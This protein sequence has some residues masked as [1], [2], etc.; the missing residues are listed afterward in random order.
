MKPAASR[1]ARPGQRHPLKPSLQRRPKRDRHGSD[2]QKSCAMPCLQALPQ[3]EKVLNLR[4]QTYLE[5]SVTTHLTASLPGT[6]VRR[7]AAQR[8][9]SSRPRS[10]DRLKLL[11]HRR[12]PDIANRKSRRSNNRINRAACRDRFFRQRWCRTGRTSQ[13]QLTRIRVK[14]RVSICS[15]WFRYQDLS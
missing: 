12:N 4:G 10:R 15:D 3:S 14:S 1:S 13:I 9:M 6:T 8:R 7:A 2:L 5:L 11:S